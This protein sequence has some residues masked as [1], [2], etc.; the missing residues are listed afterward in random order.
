M[1]Y[2]VMTVISTVG[3]GNPYNTQTLQI[4]IIISLI[5]IAIIVIPSKSS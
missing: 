5:I 2:F 4:V 3:Y 1:I